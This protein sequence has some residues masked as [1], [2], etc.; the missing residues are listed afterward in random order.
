MSEPSTE[1]Y[2]ASKA[3]VVGLSHALSQSLA[4]KVRVNAILPGWIDTTGGEEI[5]AEDHAFQPAGR[6]GK[7]EDVAEMCVFLAGPRAGFITGQEFVIDG[8]ITK[9]M[10]YPD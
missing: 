4:G 3:G 5:R 2:S 6:V 7:P 9:K 8:G 10:I 1:A